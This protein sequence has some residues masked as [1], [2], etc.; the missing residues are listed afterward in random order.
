MRRFLSSWLPPLNKQS[1]KPERTRR[2]LGLEWLEDR[3]V[4]ALTLAVAPATFAENAGLA[5]AVG[6]VTRDG[7]L[8]QALTVTLTSSDTTELTV[9]ASVTFAIGQA[10]ANF[11]ITAVDDAQL[12][13]TQTVTITAAAALPA[14]G[15]D[16]TFGDGGY[17]VIPGTSYNISSNF[18]DAKVQPDG[19]VLIGLDSTVSGATWAIARTNADGS[20]DTSFG[21]GGVV[22]TNFPSS[23]DGHADGIAVQSDGKIVVVGKVTGG[24]N[25]GDWGIARY[26]SDGTLDTTFGTTIGGTNLRTGVKRIN[27]LSAG[28]NGGWAYDVLVQADG[29]VLITGSKFGTTTPTFTVVRLLANGDLDAGFGS[30]GEASYNPDPGNTTFAT[31][32]AMLL[33][34]DGKIV[35]AGILSTG[36]GVLRLN[37]DGTLDSTFGTGGRAVVARN[38]F[39]PVAQPG[40]YGTPSG[41]LGVALQADG[42]IVVGGSLYTPSSDEDMAAFRLNVDGT[43]DTTFAGDGTFTLDFGYSDQVYDLAVLPG[44]PI[45]LAGFALVSPQGYNSALVRLTPDGALDASFDGDGKWTAPPLP[46]TF[47]QLWAIDLTAGGTKAV[48][49]VAYGDDVRVARFNADTAQAAAVVTVTDD[50]TRPVAAAD[51]YTIAE[52]ATLTVGAPGVLAN[53]SDLDGIIVSARLGTG[54]LYGSVTLNAN[55]SFTY[56]PQANFSGTDS[57]TYF[58]VDDDNIQSLAA[59]VTITVTAA[60]RAFGPNSLLISTEGGNAGYGGLLYEYTRTGTR[61]RAVSIP[62]GAQPNQP[63]EYAR[64][65]VFDPTTGAAR[66][67]NGSNDA[68]LSTF[69]P[70]DPSW[71]HRTVAGWNTTIDGVSAPLPLTGGIAVYRNYVFATDMSA[72]LGQPDYAKGILRYNGL[73]GGW[74]RFADY[75]SPLA[76]FT[77]IDLTIGLDGKLYALSGSSSGG[78]TVAVFDPETM[79]L[80]RF[81]NLPR[82]VPGTTGASFRAIAVDAQ[83]RIFA[84]S[85]VNTLVRFSA[86]GVVEASL[87][88]FGPSPNGGT[89]APMDVDVA[90]DGTVAVGTT[91]GYVAVTNTALQAPT[92]FQAGTKPVFVGFAGNQYRPVISVSDAVVTEGD[93]GTTTATFTFTLTR[94]GN[95]EAVGADYVTANVTAVPGADYEY[96]SGAVVFDPGE[97]TKTVTVTV[98]SDQLGELDE[99]FRLNITG[100]SSNAA[101][102]RFWGVGTIVDDDRTAVSASTSGMV[103]DDDGD[104]NFDTAVLTGNPLTVRRFATDPGPGDPT[105]ERAVMEYNVAAL[106]GTDVAFVNFDFRVNAITSDAKPVYVVAYTGNGTIEAPGDAGGGVVVATFTPT[107]LGL[108]S[109]LLNRNQVMAL[110]NGSASGYLGIR[111]QGSLSPT[112]FS[113]AGP[114]ATIDPPRLTFYDGAPPSVTITDASVTEGNPDGSSTDTPMTFTVTL[115]KPADVPVNVTYTTEGNTAAA[116][117]DFTPV[118]GTLTFNPGE[119]Q[120]TITVLVKRDATYERD[121]RFTVFLQADNAVVADGVAEG[122]IRNDDAAPVVTVDSP[123]ITEGHSGTRTLTFTLALT[124]STAL[125]A[126]VDYAT[127]DGTAVAGS[128]YDATSGRVTFAP[129]ET[130]KTVSVTVRG[131]TTF[132]PSEVFGLN[133]TPVADVSVGGPGAGTITNDDALPTLSVG[134]PSVVEGND[135]TAHLVFNVSLSNLSYQDVSF[136]FAAVGGTAVAGADYAA[137]S[138]TVTIAA[139]Q[140]TGTIEV[141]VNG[142]RLY[143]RDETVLLNLSNAVNVTLGAAQATGTIADD[144]ARPTVS[145]SDVTVTEGNSGTATA[146]FTLTLSGASAFPVTLGYA[147][148]DGTAAAGTDYAPASGTVT[149]AP[150]ELVKTV[151]VAV[152]G[153]TAAETD[154]TFFLDLSGDAADIGDGRGQATIINDDVRPTIGVNSVS[155]TEGD[156]G[157]KTLT[158]TLTLSAPSSEA[159]RVGYTTTAG[160]AAAGA[161]LTAATGT[162]EFAPGQTSATVAVTVR[163]ETDLEGDETF[164]LDLSNAVN[165]SIAGTGRGTGTILNDDFAPVASAGSDQTVDEGQVVRFAGSATD[166]DG[167]ALTYSWDFGDGTTGSGAAPTHVYADNG[168][169]TARL[170]VSDGHGGASTDEVVITVRSV[171]P[172]PAVSGPVNAVRGQDRVFT[173][174]ASDPPPTDAAAGYTFLVEWGDGTT[175]SVT[176]RV[177]SATLSHTWTAAGNYSVRVT[178]TDKNG[179]SASRTQAVA[180][181]VAALQN[182]TLVVGGTTGADAIRVE[183][184]SAAQLRVTIGSSVVGT[185]APTG[186]LLVYAQDGADTVTLASTQVGRTTYSVNRPAYLFGGGGNDALDARGATAG[187]VLVGGGGNDTLY[188]GSGDD[189]LIGGAGADALRGGSGED[190][191]IGGITDFDADLAALRALRAEWVRTDADL[192][193]RI[194]HLSGTAAG[195]LNGSY[196]LIAATIRDDAAVDTLYG[197]G[198]GDWFFRELGLFPDQVSD[199]KKNETRTDLRR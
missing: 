105:D 126:T 188:G 194:R 107:A 136:D 180:V 5:A 190:I 154:E 7:D 109:L 195:G 42:R 165:G 52:N 13:G 22:H 176:N 177:Q 12:D 103:R 83:G 102:G 98:L 159:V 63:L 97:T 131:D 118:S 106:R 3:S 185:Y 39:D 146:T 31:P 184:V 120:K 143:E 64:D 21:T 174:S 34:S 147:T 27:F 140:T 148:A 84:G 198:D 166:A 87:S 183:A 171:A 192:A 114:A 135:G 91:G 74:E 78:N 137:T 175:S 132:E 128:D 80:E 93:S 70:S 191:L 72:A 38:L 11:S 144:E 169:Y 111:L 130:T 41:G 170:T 161:D 67:F 108:Y 181:T 196:R 65:V 172:T 167:D 28:G 36:F 4:P 186:D 25:N 49:V 85:T 100:V 89:G 55:G 124:G 112:N 43:L 81:I 57:F 193:T 79:V 179:G 145:V 117:S 178:A 61:L 86:A 160:T 197:E 162:V 75:N 51:G 90:A 68:Y 53:D 121:E 122:W 19:K 14:V 47:E 62:D 110:V 115:S 138:G 82:T 59:T 40:Y 16:P 71:T 45:L 150:G 199:A 158:F 37:T 32:H 2:P 15:L 88:L 99:T 141:V 33:Q 157:T 30:N 129:G 76:N 189:L 113:I 60:P 163:G 94:F 173:F 101:L 77:F 139:G 104:G 35:V 23:T 6:T 152:T 151:T 26:N 134:N 69:D 168:T 29:K 116:G 155:V 149:F 156:S 18:P 182:G 8:S 54:P 58:A 95:N 125:P 50:E 46:S 96:T 187:A 48:G 10:S 17:R 56:T 142:D 1:R 9:P 123:N 92:Y 73:T 127:A 153:D 164:F 44:G 20:L 119:T 66:V 24:G 133:L